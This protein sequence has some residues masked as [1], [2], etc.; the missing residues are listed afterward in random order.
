M[1]HFCSMLV[2]TKIKPTAVDQSE[3]ELFE[4]PAESGQLWLNLLKSKTLL[5]ERCSC[6]NDTGTSLVMFQKNWFQIKSIPQIK[7]HDSTG[8]A[9]TQFSTIYFSLSKALYLTTPSFQGAYYSVL[10]TALI[11][12]AVFLRRKNGNGATA[13]KCWIVGLPH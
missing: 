5:T 10:G 4:Q 1:Q 13:E 12:H 3:M 7:R 2:M 6:P 9:A 8:I 11:S